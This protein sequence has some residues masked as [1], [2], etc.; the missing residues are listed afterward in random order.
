MQLVIIAGGKGTRLKER[1]GHLPKPMVKIGGKPLL[2]HQI[3]LA[4][5]H[6]ITEILL[7]TGYGARHI[8]HYF[9][10]GSRWGVHLQYHLECKPLGTAGAV[11]DAFDKLQ[12]RFIV[13]YGDTMLNVDLRRFAEAHPSGASA[14]LFLH[15]NDHPQ[16]SDLVEVNDANDVVA[17]HPY[18]HPPDRYFANLVNAA[19]YVVEKDSLIS[20]YHGRDTHTYPLDF[21]KHVFPALLEN[22]SRLH[23][24]VSREYI[25]DAGTPARLDRVIAH[26]ESGRIQNGSLS[27]SL[28]AIF[29]DRD[30]TLNDDKGWLHSPD[31]M[32][33]LPG[34]AEAVRAINESGRLAVVI[35]NQPVIARGECTEEGL[36]LIHNKLEWLLGEWNAYLDGI[37][38]CPHHPDKGF[39][40]E[41]EE[42]KFVCSCRKPAPGLLEVAAKEMNIDLRRSWMIGDR[43]ADV[44]AA[45]NFGIRSVLVRTG[46]M[47]PQKC[48]PDATAENVLNAVHFILNQHDLQS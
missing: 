37:Y 11:L 3:V 10:D 5:E 44:Q 38:F 33:L 46:R 21:G 40:G 28:P 6:G 32:H 9:G 24:Y 42:L 39:P 30:G 47:G 16:D 43:D 17:F 15:P 18:P 26:Y 31:Q 14:T 29:L 1:L 35:T 36:K 23:G 34:A 45:A 22:G 8:E 41:R 27:T 7:L 12:A 4:R 20:W 2:E 48:N 25:K 13:M 19:L